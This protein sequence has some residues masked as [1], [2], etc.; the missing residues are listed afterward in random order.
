MMLNY[1][2]QKYYYIIGYN[3]GNMRDEVGGGQIPK[4]IPRSTRR[5]RAAL[6]LK[7]WADVIG[8]VPVTT[9]D[10]RDRGVPLPKGTVVYLKNEGLILKQKNKYV[11]TQRGANL[12]RNFIDY[13]RDACA[14]SLAA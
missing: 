14:V 9:S 5:E 1:Y 2:C 10:A 8:S 6:A 12:G 13:G 7:V 11:L 4:Q 3:K